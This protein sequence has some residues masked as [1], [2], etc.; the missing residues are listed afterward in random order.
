MDYGYKFA[1]I[2]QD[3]VVVE[4][5]DSYVG[6]LERA[7]KLMPLAKIWYDGSDDLIEDQA[8][9][10]PMAANAKRSLPVVSSKA[11]E[12]DEESVD[13]FKDPEQA[14][15]ILR[16]DPIPY[17][18]VMKMSLTEAHRRLVD[19]FP[20]Q[21]LHKSTRGLDECVTKIGA[22][23]TPKDMAESFFGQNYKLAGGPRPGLPPSATTGLSLLPAQSWRL[24][25]E[26]QDVKK[27]IRRAPAYGIKRAN[28]IDGRFPDYKKTSTCF[29]STPE[30]KKA[31]LVFSGNNFNDRYNTIKKYAL[32]QSFF[33]ENHAFMRM[34]VEN[35]ATFERQ[36][37][38]SGVIPF[39]R[40][41]VYSDIP[42]TLLSPGTVQAFPGVR[43]YDYTKVASRNPWD[44]KTKSYGTSNYDL[45]FSYS[46]VP[47]NLKRLNHEVVSNRRRVA[48]TFAMVGY[49]KWTK[50]RVPQT[51]PRPE[52]DDKR[53]WPVSAAMAGR[54]KET[55]TGLPKEFL[56][57]EVI[58]GDQSDFRPY[59]APYNL[60]TGEYDLEPSVV[61]L[62]WK[63]PKASR[64][65]SVEARVF[66]VPGVLMEDMKT[67][68]IMDAPR[69]KTEFG[70]DSER[71]WEG[72]N[73]GG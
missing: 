50:S 13:V 16:L 26:D 25:K 21:R 38:D 5:A 15:G 67:F 45:T 2:D 71:P 72:I 18:E 14:L 69:Y 62:R 56:G 55:W 61:G 12:D 65:T 31:C 60:D 41:N 33:F 32:T 57:L 27:T 64:T 51:P 63:I 6:A 3:G 29:A 4:V 20:T 48:V 7:S 23:K 9:P 17:K 8:A 66:I 59:D 10:M 39:V 73:F 42:W 11:A 34:L 52:S 54:R 68:V 46:G 49:S 36:C 44:P 22:Y 47:A 53:T 70:E 37:K 24:D 19:M 28:D 58:D 40:L 1:I 35:I 30:C 43:F